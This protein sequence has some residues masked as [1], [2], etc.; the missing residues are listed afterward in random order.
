LRSMTSDRDDAMKRYLSIV[1]S[2]QSVQEQLHVVALEFV[3]LRRNEAQLC[4]EL[5][6]FNGDS[7]PQSFAAAI[8][9][10]RQRLARQRDAESADMQREVEELLREWGQGSSDEV[11]TRLDLE[12]VRSAKKR[13]LLKEQND[14][15]SQLQ[16][17][18]QLLRKSHQATNTIAS[19]NA[20]L[21]VGDETLP[22]SKASNDVDVQ[23]L[24]RRV[25]FC[26]TERRS[27]A[28]LVDSLS[29]RLAEEEHASEEL[30]AALGNV[31][32]DFSIAQVLI[33]HVLLP[34]AVYI[35]IEFHR[36]S[37]SRSSNVATG[38]PATKSFIEVALARSSRF[39]VCVVDR[40]SA[41][42]SIEPSNAHLGIVSAFP[43]SSQFFSRTLSCSFRF[44]PL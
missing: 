25:E 23:E 33:A 26:E 21:H 27:S 9:G 5:R 29:Q 19:S 15:I 11:L 17:E 40:S 12:A 4:L 3:T 34:I 38:S 42:S 41:T 30:K 31:Q 6:S 14:M 43:P 22:V 10:I 2:L 37:A 39:A 20:A 7:S 44:L 36:M 1:A 8:A 28:I 13:S 16:A 35:I 24:Q 18:L 32:E